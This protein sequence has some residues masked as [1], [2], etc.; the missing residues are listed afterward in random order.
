[1]LSIFQL[2]DLL[3]MNDKLR[4]ENQK[5]ERIN[6]PANANHYWNYRIHIPLEQLIKEKEFNHELKDYIV[7]SG[8]R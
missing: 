5:E 7:N 6:D 8:R 3:G 4:R 1:M 2:Q